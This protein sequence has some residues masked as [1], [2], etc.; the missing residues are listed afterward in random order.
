MSRRLLL[1]ALALC[2]MLAVAVSCQKFDVAGAPPAEPMLSE[3]A[4][5]GAAE[6]KPADV[7]VK[8][9]TGEGM[10]GEGQRGEVPV[11]EN[12]A[13]KGRKLIRDGHMRVKVK[14]VDAARASLERMAESAGGFV[15]NVNAQ[16]YSSTKNTDV[17]MRIPASG[18]LSFVEKI[19][20][21]GFVEEEGFD[22]TD[23]TDQY[24]DLDRRIKTQ[25]AL[26]ARLEQLIQDKSYQFKDLLDVER[27]LARLR[28]E[29]ESMQGSLRG[30]DDR[31]S[32]STLRVSM[33]QEVV[34]QVVPPDSVFSPLV[35]ALENAGPRFKGSVRGIMALAG[36]LL[37][38]VVALT[39][40]L[41][42][43]IP[44]WL[45]LRALW[46]RRQARK[47]K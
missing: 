21:L 18:F 40:W 5:V 25:E 17:T 11:A 43:L 39:P 4:P 32:L 37:N 24:V 7:L 42:I 30:L 13:L 23:V 44:G 16:S 14:D 29:I 45:V 15:S 31:I 20:A 6:G 27:E 46:R 19:R 38:F 2:A 35:S 10:G 1:A 9:A 36:G 26:A 12:V 34:Q 47:G 3:M 8:D 33:Y 22:V 28:L 41:V